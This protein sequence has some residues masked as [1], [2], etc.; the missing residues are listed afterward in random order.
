[1]GRIQSLI[2]YLFKSS[3]A[4]D[5]RNK[6]Q[7]RITRDFEM[8]LQ[9]AKYGTMQRYIREKLQRVFYPRFIF[10]ELSCARARLVM[11]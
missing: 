2:V 3:S 5:Y 11:I 4:T 10:D 8:K 6:K 1:M 9:P 7:N